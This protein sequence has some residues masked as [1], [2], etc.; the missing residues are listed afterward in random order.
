M[1]WCRWLVAISVQVGARHLEDRDSKSAARE[2]DSVSRSSSLGAKR[3]VERRR[4]DAGAQAFHHRVAP[5][6]GF[7]FI[8]AFVRPAARLRRF[9]ALRGGVVGT[10]MRR[11]GGTTSFQCAATLAARADGRAL[12]GTGLRIAPWR[13]ELPAI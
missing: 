4:W 10:Q 2:T 9:A 1:P 5:E 7:G 3:D 12:L 8:G 11:R 13:R 6:H